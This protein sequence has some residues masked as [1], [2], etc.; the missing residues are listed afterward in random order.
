MFP[1]IYVTFYKNNFEPS[2]I[3]GLDMI[4]NILEV[5]EN[6]PVTFTITNWSNFTPIEGIWVSINDNMG[7][8]PD[9]IEC[10]PDG[11]RYISRACPDSVSDVEGNKYKVTHLAGYCWTSNL[12]TTLYDDGSII[13]FANPYYHYLYP[14]I[15]FNKETFGLL[16]TWF[17]AVGVSEDF[18]GGLYDVVQG[19]CPDGWHIPS[20]AALDLLKRYPASDLKSVNYWL[21]PGFDTYGFDARPAGRYNG[22]IDRYENLYGYTG[23]WASDV[24]PGII[25]NY[26]TLAYYCVILENNFTK[27]ADA[28]SVRCIMD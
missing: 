9:Q 13:A 17:S 10:P 18:S 22:L 11:R 8:Y 15:H 23:W 2:A 5:G 12:L 1:P 20:Q 21:I 16:Y 4:D 26:Y 6:Y 19:I 7:A 14:D 28:L 25:A 3:M 24:N 27:R